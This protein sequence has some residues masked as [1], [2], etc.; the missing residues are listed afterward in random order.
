MT[1]VAPVL[2]AFFSDRLINQRRASGHTVAAYRDTFRLLLRFAEG[3]A[4][5]SPAELAFEDLDAAMIGA[6]LEHLESSRGNTPRTR[7]AR[8]AAVRAFYRFAA[9]REPAHAALIQRVLAIPQKRHKRALVEFLTPAEV[10]ALLASPDRR[11]RIGRRDHALMLVAVQTGLRVSELTGLVRSDINLDTGP[12]IR[13]EGKGRK[14]RC[15]PL[16]RP[17]VGVLRA[18]HKETGKAPGDV[19]F[20]GPREGA[21][22]RDAVWRLVAKYV[23]IASQRCPSIGAKHVSPHTL[24][25]TAAMQLLAAGVDRSVIALLLG[26]E[27]V[28]TT[29]IYL[30]ADLTLKQRALDRTRP[31]EA[32]AGRYKPTDT[33]LDF[34][35]SL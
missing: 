16:T 13:C 1:N 8:L 4:G 14:E 19:V 18:W 10:E 20:P 9:L 15:T 6:F 21:L 17:A 29:Q 33:L 26:H 32:S 12:H 28:E 34:L 27:Q 5:K 2:E 7:N 30:H 25:H 31:I 3:R 24:R 23:L 22:S 35:E 11:T